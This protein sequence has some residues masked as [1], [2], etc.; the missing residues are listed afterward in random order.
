MIAVLVYALCAL[1]SIGCALLL[2]RNYF[3]SRAKLLA[4]SALCFVC[5]GLANVVL[6]LDLVVVGG[7]DLSPYRTALTFVGLIMLVYGLIWETS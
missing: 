3:R 6:F 1:T 5:L 2:L 4:W 7:T